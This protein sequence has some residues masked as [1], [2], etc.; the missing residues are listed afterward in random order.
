MEKLEEVRTTGTES[1]EANGQREL[2]EVLKSGKAKRT[3]EP[4]AMNHGR[5]GD[6]E[7]Q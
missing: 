5:D 1:W 6:R 4:L 2:I 7:S 3:L